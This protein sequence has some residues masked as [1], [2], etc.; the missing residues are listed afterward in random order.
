MALKSTGLNLAIRDNLSEILSISGQKKTTLIR[1]ISLFNGH[2]Q[3][4]ND[5]YFNAKK[6]IIAMNEAGKIINRVSWNINAGVQNRGVI[7]ENVLNTFESI[8]LKSKNAYLT[9]RLKNYYQLQNGIGQINFIEADQFL[10]NSWTRIRARIS[11]EDKNII[12]S[13][14]DKYGLTTNGYVHNLILTYFN[15][16]TFY[17][18]QTRPMLQYFIVAIKKVI[19]NLNQIIFNRKGLAFDNEVQISSK[20]KNQ[21]TA[22]LSFLRS[23]PILYKGKKLITNWHERK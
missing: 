20:M 11:E 22:V 7:S 19:V 17:D 15:Q 9:W 8:L 2:L 23:D 14:A 10:F 21:A 13:N 4:P 16:S 5:D 1:N 12:I 18:D 6:N 3:E